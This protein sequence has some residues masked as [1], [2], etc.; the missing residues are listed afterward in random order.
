MRLKLI[1]F[2]VS[3]AKLAISQ[4]FVFYQ[5]IQFDFP[6]F[7]SDLPLL[8]VASR[9]LFVIVPYVWGHHTR[10]IEFTFYMYVKTYL[11]MSVF[12]VL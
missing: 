1:E 12:V 7:Q 6:I 10:L 11:Y 9:F 8:P 2:L 5:A 3:I 4:A